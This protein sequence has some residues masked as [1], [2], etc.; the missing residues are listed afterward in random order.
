MKL[1]PGQKEMFDSDVMVGSKK[2]QKKLMREMRKEKQ[3]ERKSKFAAKNKGLK[4]KKPKR[5]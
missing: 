1:L 2:K 5:R 4:V 3:N